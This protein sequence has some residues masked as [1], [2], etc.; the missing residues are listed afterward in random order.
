MLS[1]L[2]ALTRVI[3]TKP[4]GIESIIIPIYRWINILQRETIT[5]SRLHSSKG[6]KWASDTLYLTTETVCFGLNTIL[7]HKYYFFTRENVIFKRGKKPWVTVWLT[8]KRIVQMNIKS[9][10]CSSQLW[11]HGIY[12]WSNSSV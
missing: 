6:Q 2:H 10:K 1:P 7:L 3:L 8:A 12:T 11:T 5:Y 9:L 4:Y